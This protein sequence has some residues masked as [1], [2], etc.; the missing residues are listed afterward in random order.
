MCNINCVTS[1]CP[2]E[3]YMFLVDQMSGFVENI[4]IFSLLHTIN[5]INVKL[6]IMVLLIWLYLFHYTLV[7]LTLFQGHS[8]VKQF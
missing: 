1:V 8:S 4:G 2:R 5:V 7:T 6:C 3:I